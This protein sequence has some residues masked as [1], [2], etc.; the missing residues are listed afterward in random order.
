MN[1]V[2]GNTQ[3]CQELLNNAAEKKVLNLETC[4]LQDY[5]RSLNGFYII[6]FKYVL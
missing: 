4:R 3:L 6:I 2:I 5:K 1:N